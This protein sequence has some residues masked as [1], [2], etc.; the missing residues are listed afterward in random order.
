MPS[1][2]LVCSLAWEIDRDPHLFKSVDSYDEGGRPLMVG[3]RRLDL[4][5]N[6]PRSLFWQLALAVYL[7]RVSEKQNYT[8]GCLDNPSRSKCPVVP[9]LVARTVKPSST[10]RKIQGHSPF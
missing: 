3:Y 10:V 8:P 9:Q 1:P 7:I 4:E 6:Q 2:A 5:L